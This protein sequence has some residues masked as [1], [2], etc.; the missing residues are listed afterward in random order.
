MLSQEQHTDTDWKEK[1]NELLDE[2]DIREK[3]WAHDKQNLLKS[4][5]RLTFL[6]QGNN[7][8]LDKKL[9]DLKEKLKQAGNALP[10]KQIDD[11]INAVLKTKKDIDADKSR[12][13]QLISGVIDLLI[14]DN[15]FENHTA[16]L[17][18]V[19]EELKSGET[20]PILK[21]KQVNK[22]ISNINNDSP[23]DKQRPQPY[24]VFLKRL[25]E[26]KETDAELAEVCRNTIKLNSEKDLLTS[27]NQCIE[28][29]NRQTQKTNNN[30]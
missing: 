23:V 1:Y 4:V 29:I 17:K 12:T 28:K 30:K 7:D 5:L 3:D 10:Q 21:L 27:I 18:S 22:V 24:K 13:G 20:S 11:T 14:K 6:Y 9:F 8:L 16:P 2:H 25:A 19:Q 26:H 15:R